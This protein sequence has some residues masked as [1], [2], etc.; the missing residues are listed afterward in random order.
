MA[1]K[2]RGEHSR[3]RAAAPRAESDDVE[4]IEGPSGSQAELSDGVIGHSHSIFPDRR[5]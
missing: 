4:P 1:G 2:T 3:I 5:R